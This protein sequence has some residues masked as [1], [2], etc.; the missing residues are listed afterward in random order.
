VAPRSRLGYPKVR[1]QTVTS[2]IAAQKI[3]DPNEGQPDF[4]LGNAKVQQRQPFPPAVQG[5]CAGLCAQMAWPR[6]PQPVRD[7]FIPALSAPTSTRSSTDLHVVVRVPIRVVDDHRVR[8]SEVDAQPASPGGQEEH[9][10]VGGGRIELLHRSLPVLPRNRAVNAAR[11]VTLLVQVVL[12][13]VQNLGHLCGGRKGERRGG[14]GAGA[15]QKKSG[16]RRVRTCVFFLGSVGRVRTSPFPAHFPLGGASR[17]RTLASASAR[18]RARSQHTWEKIRTL[19]FPSSFF[20]MR[21]TS[22]ILPH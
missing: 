7:P 14:A 4:D 9:K 2:R 18:R 3:S 5:A 20:K 12:Q 21:S 19:C 16:K 17:I 6:A 15:A 1:A 8:R 13:K 11:T 10:R 22:F